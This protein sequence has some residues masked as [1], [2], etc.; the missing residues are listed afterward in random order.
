MVT[1]LR[2]PGVVPG[3]V[4]TVVVALDPGVVRGDGVADGHKKGLDF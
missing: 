2:L 4:P 1:P 3:V